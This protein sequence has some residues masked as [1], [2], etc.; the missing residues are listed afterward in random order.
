M[1]QGKCLHPWNKSK[2]GTFQKGHKN[3]NSELK[4]CF[5]KGEI[6]CPAEINRQLGKQRYLAGVHPFVAKNR[7]AQ[8]LANKDQW[9]GLGKK[10]WKDL[11]RKILRRD[12]YLCMSCGDDLHKRKYNCHHI[13]PFSVSKDNS[14]ENLT[15]LCIPCHASIEYFT[16]IALQSAG[17][18]GVVR[19]K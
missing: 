11:S 9:H 10:A 2:E 17:G 3:F 14:E 13:R 15:S 8:L 6:H 19:T 5:K 1:V 18:E 16:Q 7:L 12:N 4:G